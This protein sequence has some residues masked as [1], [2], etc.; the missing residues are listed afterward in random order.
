M[1]QPS[2]S[3]TI[4]EP[5]W[6]TG[7]VK[8]EPRAPLVLPYM[9]YLLL[10]LLTD[11]LPDHTPYNQLGIAMHVIA[12][13]WATWL[14][15]HHWPSLGKPHFLIALVAGLFAAW[16]WV[17]GQHRLAGIEFGNQNLGD[18][19]SVGMRPPFL[20][21]E[22]HEFES[23]ASRFSTAPAF[24]SHVVLKIS[25]AVTVVPVVEELFWRGFILRA[26]VNWNRSE[27]VPLGTF[28]WFSFLGSSLLSVAQ[29]PANWGVSILCWM[30]FNALFYWKK[31]LFCL[32]LTH[33]ITN[34]A[35]YIYVVREGDWQFW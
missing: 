17:A 31:S 23:V 32:I 5:L 2:Q 34:L 12:A 26:F 1:E 15:R 3:D 11:F 30:L 7:L 14:L 18:V 28:T 20:K 21:L 10:M 29:H 6:V 35:L 4:R 16:M 33:A 19:L 9:A 13:A 22:P 25:R 8:A 27:D 24:W